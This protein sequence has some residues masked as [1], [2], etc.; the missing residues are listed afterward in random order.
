MKVLHINQSDISGGAA[1]AA[2]RLHSGLIDKGIDSYL[3][4]DQKKTRNNCVIP[5]SR[6]RLLDEVSARI[7]QYSGLNY[8]NIVGSKRIQALHEF[9][10]SKILHFHNLHGA[11][12]NYLTIPSLTAQK[13]TVWTLHDMWSFT[14]HCAYSFDC[15]RWKIG[16]GHCP[17]PESYPAIKR[18]SSAWEIKLKSWLYSRSNLT[19]VCPS[20][21]L[22][23]QA[24]V[25]ILRN[26]PIHHIPYGLDT[27]LYHPINQQ[28]SRSAFNIP[29]DRLVILVA[30]D[31]LADSRKGADLLLPALKSL[32][33]SL[34]SR[35]FLLSFGNGGEKISGAL[36]MPHL[37]LGHISSD[38][39]KA[40]AY[41]AADVFVL[42][43]RADN[44]PLV[45]QESMACG[46][47]MVSFDV[48]GVPELVRHHKTGYLAKP[49][50]VQDFKYRIQEILENKTI[51][52]V[53]GENCRKIAVKEYSLDLQADRY[54]KLYQELL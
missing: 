6:N 40:L 46:T 8:I 25:S 36:D 38:R 23:E 48:G 18:D 2:H 49:E 45:L 27:T 37:N 34:K 22:K 53:L 13:P 28:L 33:D 15:D 52:K 19:F 29:T 3:A 4:V 54:I 47:P 50:D 14:G 10:D 51:L 42:P 20:R 30:A 39:L 17:Y 1:I 44:L 11:Y 21:W 24:Q 43:T 41:S 31:S 5:I 9:S 32:P 16:C 12:F 35:I 7:T 26:F